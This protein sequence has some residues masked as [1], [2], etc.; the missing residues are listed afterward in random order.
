MEL[1]ALIGA[2]R[3][4]SPESRVTVYSD[5][6][7]AIRTIL[8]R[9]PV[10]EQAGWRL[11]NGQEP[12]NLEQVK[13]V[14]RLSRSRPGCRIEWVAAHRSN[15]WNERAHMLASR[16]RKAGRRAAISSGWSVCDT[17]RR[18]DGKEPSLPSTTTGPRTSHR[19]PVRRHHLKETPR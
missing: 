14:L 16:A 4:V 8:E 6:Q 13:Q 15:H 3:A 19:K 18:E 2:L 10:W 9:A 7:I 12:R 11:K 1:Q 5:S 17:D